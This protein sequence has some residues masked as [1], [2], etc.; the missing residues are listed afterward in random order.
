MNFE[1][2]SN[3]RLVTR[4]RHSRAHTHKNACARVTQSHLISQIRN[5]KNISE[6]QNVPFS[7][8]SRASVA[9][10]RIM[11]IQTSEGAMNTRKILLS[12]K[13]QWNILPKGKHDICREPC[14]SGRPEVWAN[15][16]AVRRAPRDLLA[17]YA[18]FLQILENEL[19]HAKCR[20]VTNISDYFLC[21]NE[22][23]I[24]LLPIHSGLEWRWGS[25]PFA[26]LP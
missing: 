26:L 1:P 3:F 7:R 6:C 21:P 4:N 8:C 5:R 11:D 19:R 20:R 16:S 10:G 18:T 25:A 13:Q 12:P 22:F 2:Y 15:V 24:K 14:S 23:E 9:R 17:A